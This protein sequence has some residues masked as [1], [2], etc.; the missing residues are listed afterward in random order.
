MSI[1]L[2]VF[3]RNNESLLKNQNHI[4]EEVSSCNK[5]NSG[6]HDITEI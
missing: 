5:S 1:T 2:I 6:L 3:N 4:E